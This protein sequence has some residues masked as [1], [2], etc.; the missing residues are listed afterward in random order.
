MTATAPDL[1]GITGLLEANDILVEFAVARPD[2]IE[3]VV[4]PDAYRDADMD[5]LT[6]GWTP[7]LGWYADSQCQPGVPVTVKLGI[8]HDAVP[9]VVV[10]AVREFLDGDREY[11]RVTR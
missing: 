1:A 4:H 3:F 5:D 11:E 7:E 10:V 9:A 8:P 6:F 2:G